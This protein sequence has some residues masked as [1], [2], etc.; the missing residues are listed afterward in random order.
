MEGRKGA[1][2]TPPSPG[3]FAGL[4]IWGQGFKVLG[5]IESMSC[6]CAPVDPVVH[7]ETCPLSHLNV[8]VKMTV[9]CN[10]PSLF[11]ITSIPGNT[12]PQSPRDDDFT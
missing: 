1:Y 10:V 8:W 7:P 9:V 2:F 12:I 5:E 11:N 6:T 3:D 4:A